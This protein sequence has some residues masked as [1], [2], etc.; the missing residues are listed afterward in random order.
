MKEITYPQFQ[1]LF[2]I[3]DGD[4]FSLLQ[5]TSVNVIKSNRFLLV[6]QVLKF[7]L[8]CFARLTRAL[9]TTIFEASKRSC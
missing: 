9:Q 1:D 2:R 4:R 6:I 7:K 3:N 5:Y 8:G